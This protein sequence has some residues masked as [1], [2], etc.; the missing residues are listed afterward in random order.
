MQLTMVSEV[1]LDSSGALRATSVENKG[2]SATTTNPQKNKN[3]NNMTNDVLWMKKG[4]RIQQRQ[5]K[6]KAIVAI[7]LGPAF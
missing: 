3:S 1:P 6:L 7:F 2:E 5:D 4:E